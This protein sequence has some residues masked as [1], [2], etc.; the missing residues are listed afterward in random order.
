MATTTVWVTRWALTKGV[1]IVEATLSN[2]G[3][4]ATYK[5][6]GYSVYL[7][8]KDFHL[9]DAKAK[10]HANEKVAK[11]IAALEKQLVKLKKLAF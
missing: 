9:S 8:G 2:S 6:E 7:H 3:E 10:E 11:K 1:Y 5:Q 4:M